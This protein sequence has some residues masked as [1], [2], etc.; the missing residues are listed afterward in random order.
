MIDVARNGSGSSHTLA[1][2]GEEGRYNVGSGGTG[3]TEVSW[4][5]KGVPGL[6]Q[7]D[8]LGRTEPEKTLRMLPLE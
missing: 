2:V 6:N 1:E 4:P 8:D 7:Y 3:G 5:E